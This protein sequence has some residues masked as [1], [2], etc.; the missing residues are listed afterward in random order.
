MTVLYVSGMEERIDWRGCECDPPYACNNPACVAGRAAVEAYWRDRFGTSARRE[1]IRA[2]QEQELA[3]EHDWW[4]ALLER[5]DLF[6]DE[7]AEA[8][9]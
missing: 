5:A 9:A 1:A 3:E 8:R 4:D 7:Q 6:R 2:Q